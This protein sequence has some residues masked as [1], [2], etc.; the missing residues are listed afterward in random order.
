MPRRKGDD[1]NFIE[2][3]LFRIARFLESLL[4]KVDEV[5][6]GQAALD[7]AIANLGS[8]VDG[9]KSSIDQVLTIVT[10]LVTKLES[11]P[12]APDFTT[13]IASLQSISD[14]LSP[15]K[16]AADAA[17]VSGDAALGVAPGSGEAPP[18][19]PPT[20]Q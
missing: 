12:N 20:G 5:G 16:I 2:F 14:T 17:I 13:E 7:A 8:V 1:I 18:V 3:Q 10:A 11:Q 15:E 9:V 6:E 4:G 19:P